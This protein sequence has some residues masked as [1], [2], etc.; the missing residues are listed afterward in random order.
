ME[1]AF[2]KETHY[3]E[4]A[5]FIIDDS[6]PMDSRLSV[7]DTDGNDHVRARF[8]WQPRQHD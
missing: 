3:G 7:T 2:I 5:Q 8:I 4:A 6:D 1:I